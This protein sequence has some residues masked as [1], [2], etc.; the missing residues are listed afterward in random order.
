MQAA[1]AHKEWLGL[2]VKADGAFE[3][4]TPAALARYIR[5]RFFSLSL[6]QAE[7]FGVLSNGMVGGGLEETCAEG[8]YCA[9]ETTLKGGPQIRVFNCGA[10]SLNGER[11]E[12]AAAAMRHAEEHIMML[13]GHIVMAGGDGI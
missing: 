7:R 4:A 13:M 11:H 6:Q 5:E 10:V 8:G 3:P 12:S 1:K 2:G 9:I